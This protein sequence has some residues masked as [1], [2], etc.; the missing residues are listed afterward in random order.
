MWRL[1]PRQRK[2]HQ[3]EEHLHLPR[4]SAGGAEGEGGGGVG[5]GA[6][7]RPA[8]AGANF[9]D[10]TRISYRSATIACADAG[11]PRFQMT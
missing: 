2:V 5:V 1:R 6:G 7:V 3:G 8:A 11:T 9:R 10:V 4:G